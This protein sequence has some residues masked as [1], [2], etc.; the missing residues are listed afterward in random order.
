MALSPRSKH[1]AAQVRTSGCTAR[2][3]WL[4]GGCGTHRCA[5]VR[6][7]GKVARHWLD[8]CHDVALGFLMLSA[9][10][11]LLCA[12][13]CAIALAPLVRAGADEPDWAAL[14]KPLVLT[15]ENIKTIHESLMIWCVV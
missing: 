9:S 2:G 11:T 14:D 7:Q 12:A 10:R 5:Q 15:A 1:V 8:A 3:R 6:C 4:A 13:L